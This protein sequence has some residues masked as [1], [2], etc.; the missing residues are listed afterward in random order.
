MSSDI[1]LLDYNNKKIVPKST[2]VQKRLRLAAVSLLFIVS[3]FS[4]IIFILISLSPLPDLDRQHKIASFNL[5]QSIS[6]IVRLG[7][8]KERTDNIKKIIDNR[9]NYDELIANLQTKLPPG[10]S[11]ESFNVSDGKITFS[12]TS[13]SVQ[14][15]DEFLN[16]LIKNDSRF[17]KFS[18][19]TLNKISSSSE[20]NV[21]LA[22]FT[23]N[24]Q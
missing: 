13:K 10:V 16:E 6:E 5:S 24:L 2:S 8:L 3:T 18:K 20:E 21:F 1:N 11:V 22:S 12:I 14:R 9:K 15:I 17:E 23:I 7:L 4:V 19:I